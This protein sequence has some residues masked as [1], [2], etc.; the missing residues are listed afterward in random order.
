VRDPDFV[1]AAPGV[2]AHRVDRGAPG[3]A[4]DAGPEARSAGGRRTAVL[5]HGQ[6]GDENAMWIF[7]RAV[8]GWLRVAAARA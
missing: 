5:L 3:P 1:A 7:A 2:L 6:G 8:P 4:V